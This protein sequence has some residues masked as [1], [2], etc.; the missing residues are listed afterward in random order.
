MPADGSLLIVKTLHRTFLWHRGA[1]EEAVSMLRAR[2]AG[3]CIYADDATHQ[4]GVLPRPP[5]W[6]R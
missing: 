2:S 6:V 5:T 1:G 3:D 4:D